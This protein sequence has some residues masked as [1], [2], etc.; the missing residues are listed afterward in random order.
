MKK[1]WKSLLISSVLWLGAT[2]LAGWKLQQKIGDD[3]M[4]IGIIGSSDGPTSIIVNKKGKLR[5][6]TYGFFHS[7]LFFANLYSPIK[8]LAKKQQVKRY[9]ARKRKQL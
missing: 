4:A 6:W 8:L 5:G 1:V 3:A 9:I 7:S 2:A